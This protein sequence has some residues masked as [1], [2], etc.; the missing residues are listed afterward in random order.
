MCLTDNTNSVK[1][2]VPA[3][4]DT[5]LDE[6]TSNKEIP[7]L[8]KFFLHPTIFISIAFGSPAEQETV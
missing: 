1:V 8:T 4:A 3:A 6:A 5:V 7:N 2:T